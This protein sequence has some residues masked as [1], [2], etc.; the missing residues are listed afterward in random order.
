MAYEEIEQD[1]LNQQKLAAIARDIDSFAADSPSKKTAAVLLLSH[2]A[3]Q[4]GT[5]KET[6]AGGE[7]RK[8]KLDELEKMKDFIN[9]KHRLDPEKSERDFARDGL[10]S[11]I[12]QY[13][14]EKMRAQ[15]LIE[16][17]SHPGV[18]A[19]LREVTAKSNE[20]KAILD[21]RQVII[22]AQKTAR[23]FEN[24]P[25]IQIKIKNALDKNASFE[26]RDRAEKFWESEAATK[27]RSTITHKAAWAYAKAEGTQRPTTAH[28]DRAKALRQK[29]EGETGKRTIAISRDP[30]VTQLRF[31]KLIRQDAKAFK[32]ELAAK[33][34]AIPA[35]PVTSAKKHHAPAVMGLKTGK[36][37]EAEAR[38]KAAKAQ[39]KPVKNKTDDDGL[40]AGLK[41]GRQREI[42]AAAKKAAA[43]KKNHAPAVN[44]ESKPK[45]RAS[46]E[47]VEKAQKA[48]EEKQRTKNRG[49]G[50]P[51]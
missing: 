16:L 47:D 6:I 46:T 26:R 5:V 30:V 49:P 39:Q 38:Q 37:R 40:V 45:S 13:E 35:S 12:H 32:K 25:K 14:M 41:S 11:F 22:D 44:I 36:E 8:E 18:A 1:E 34:T 2:Y 51:K 48:L 19:K 29:I 3:R 50:G 17:P 20:Q 43:A 9:E 42:E 10:D 4:N 24:S 31:E 27:A 23:A 28:Y 7:E 33:A 21:A 15:A